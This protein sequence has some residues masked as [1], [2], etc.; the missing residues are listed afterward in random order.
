MMWIAQRMFVC[1]GVRWRDQLFGVEDPIGKVIRVT[2][3][4]C[5]VVATLIPKGQSLSGQDQ[6]D[7]VILPYT[8][9]Q[10]RLKGLP[11]STTSSARRSRRTR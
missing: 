2:N 6:D 8:T 9:A 5:K 4:P 3:L 11:G 7:T 1:S 10:K